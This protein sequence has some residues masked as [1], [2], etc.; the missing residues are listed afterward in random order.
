[1][2]LSQQ[3]WRTPE[4]ILLSFG[5]S[6]SFLG[7]APADLDLSAVAFAKGGRYFDGV[8]FNHPTPGDE[9][10]EAERTADVVKSGELPYMFLCGDSRTG[11]EEENRAM[12]LDESDRPPQLR[13]AFARAHQEAAHHRPREQAVLS[14]AA[15]F[16]CLMEKEVGEAR[17]RREQRAAGSVETPASPVARRHPLSDESIVL[18]LARVPAEVEVIFLTATSYTGVDFSALASVRLDV[19]DETHQM[20][21]G[22]MNLHHG[23][24]H[25]TANV[26]V[27]L[28][29]VPSADEDALHSQHW[30]IREINVGAKGF[31]FVDVIPT[32]L[33]IL[34]IPTA[35][36]M[37]VLRSIPNYS[38]RKQCVWN[39]PPTSENLNEEFETSL[40]DPQFWDVR[41]GV[42]WSGDH[43][44]DAFLVIMDEEHQRVA[45]LH[46]KNSRGLSTA[47]RRHLG[48]QHSGDC[49]S[50]VGISGD[51]ESID[52][53]VPA[54]PPN[55]HTILVG[56][57]LAGSLA[58]AMTGN[59][60]HT[61][62][63]AASSST[64][65]TT[66]QPTSIADIPQLYMRLQ[67]RSVQNPYATEVDRWDVYRDAAAAKKSDE[68]NDGLSV[69][70]DIRREGAH[71]LVLG[72]L[73]RCGDQPVPED[74]Q[75]AWASQNRDTQPPTRMPYF[76]YVPLHQL[77]PVATSLHASTS[78]AFS[79]TIAYLQSLTTLIHHHLAKRSASHYSSVSAVSSRAGS[80]VRAVPPCLLPARRCKDLLDSVRQSGWSKVFGL[81]V[82]MV[83]V[84]SL[85]PRRPDSFRCHAE[86]WVHG[87][88]PGET[89]QSLHR[90]LKGEAA[91]GDD[92][93]FSLARFL[94]GSKT[95]WAPKNVPMRTP[96]LTNAEKRSWEAGLAN[97]YFIIHV[98]DRIRLMV[99]SDASFGVGDINM[100]DHMDLF[101]RASGCSKSLVLKLHAGPSS[102]Q[103]AELGIRLTSVPVEVAAEHV[104]AKAAELEKAAA[105]E[106]R[107]KQ[108]VRIDKQ[109]AELNWCTVM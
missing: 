96:L 66:T 84:V 51:G 33:T 35:S 85:E 105:K 43:D 58:T 103:V 63:T 69:I 61:M 4:D 104:A 1:M 32:M 42:G 19:M 41:F 92:G 52:M 68:V 60:P 36:H 31:T 44:L 54:L 53:M 40:D 87:C 109:R 49:R 83:E 26:S 12:S 67:N 6:W 24:R 71:T 14:S 22:S 21:V 65:V 27:C 59:A 95:P 45:H 16:D 3:V 11:G 82:E 30:D 13:S 56:V 48:C 98:Y 99:Y 91:G 10:E 62:V 93:S 75:Q 57:S 88:G 106:E 55:A 23:A 74:I 29:R 72:A 20:R 25:G 77:V 64:P 100:M 73:V 28:M 2:D 89:R 9:L 107:A 70:G 37:D 86:A 80:D 79:G 5:L 46:P 101:T 7:R 39:R 17:W 90:S 18:Q 78:A 50:A 34:G 15:M 47:A 76:E 38:L 8:F 81:V 102:A 108:F 97:G 94:L